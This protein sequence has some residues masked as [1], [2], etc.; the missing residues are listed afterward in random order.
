[1]INAVTHAVMLVPLQGAMRAR[2]RVTPAA[3]Q[4]RVGT[5][6]RGDE[7]LG[8]RAAKPTVVE[9]VLPPRAMGTGDRLRIPDLGHVR[10]APLPGAKGT[11]RVDSPRY[12]GQACWCPTGAMRTIYRYLGELGVT[13]LVPL[14][15]AIRNSRARRRV[16][17]PHH[18]GT[19]P[20]GEE[21]DAGYQ[22]GAHDHHVGTPP[23]SDQDLAATA[24]RPSP[25]VGTPPRAMRVPRS[26]SSCTACCAGWH[27]SHGAMRA[28]RSTGH[29]CA[30]ACWSPSEGATR[31]RRGREPA[32]TTDVVGTPPQA[33]EDPRR[34]D[35]HARRARVPTPPRAMRTRN[36]GDH[37]V[38]G[39]HHPKRGPRQ[40]PGHDHPRRP[41]RWRRRAV[42]S[43][44]PRVRRRTC[45]SDRSGSV[46]KRRRPCPPGPAP[47]RPHRPGTPRTS[48]APSRIGT[49]AVPAACTA[50]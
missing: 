23:R 13:A 49:P 45:V 27:P 12:P 22:L 28:S 14:S 16:A 50:A 32:V 31:T 40:P 19:P 20:T 24:S 25:H 29:A 3:V 15:G 35:H 10:L 21:D 8:K 2:A 44:S 33:D 18:V 48:S 34:G 37:A 41:Q 38:H 42:Q 43:V 9:L 17:R 11:A 7:D 46:R 6:L 1:M 47:T 26:P 39:P 5:P 30:G 4:R 36:H